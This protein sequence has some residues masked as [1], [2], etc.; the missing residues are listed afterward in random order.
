MEWI[1]FDKDGTLI[2][3]DKSWEKIGVRL[4]DKLLETFPVHD[5]EV[6][7]R[8]LGIIDDKIVPDSVMGSGSLGDMIKSFNDVTGQ[9]TT[10]W[11]RD[12][13]QEL[14]DT[15]VPEN[16]WIEG[17]QDVIQELRNEGYKIG[18]VTSDTKKGVNQFL[19]ETQ[20]KSLFDLIISTETHA[21]EKPNPK[22]LAPLFDAYDVSPNQVAIIGD[23]AN[24]MKTAINAKLGLG[25]GVLTGIAK[26]EEL[27]EADVIIDSAKDVKQILDQYK[28]ESN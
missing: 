12:T 27:H 26:R 25:I 24:D 20:S 5:K 16:N 15:R 6:A 1:L 2:E 18:I 14:V 21:E 22:V 11:T 7:H 3:F 4:V 8:Q 28:N 10:D 17:V 13:S 9:D 19:E 23:T